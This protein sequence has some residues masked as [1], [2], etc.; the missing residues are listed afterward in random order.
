MLIGSGG[1]DHA[2]GF[3]FDGPNDAVNFA[4]YEVERTRSMLAAQG[5][6]AGQRYINGQFWISIE[7]ELRT[8][9]EQMSQF[10]LLLLAV[11]PNVSNLSGA[12]ELHYPRVRCREVSQI[13]IQVKYDLVLVRPGQLA[14]RVKNIIPSTVWLEVPEQRLD[15]LRNSLADIGNSLVDF[16]FVLGE[17]KVAVPLCS[18]QRDGGGVHGLIECM[19]KVVDDIGCDVP[20]VSW[21]PIGNLEFDDLVTRLSVH[22]LDWHASARLDECVTAFCKVGNVCFSPIDED[23]WALEMIGRKE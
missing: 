18:A 13:T 7:L 5:A 21:N 10:K 12:G 1:A 11:P 17:G 16:C 9:A 3:R 4:R 6:S 14:H 22:I 20:G 15:F 19:A 23:S 8:R 2:R